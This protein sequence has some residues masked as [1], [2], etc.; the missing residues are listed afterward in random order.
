MS[1]EHGI[2]V[3]EPCVRCAQG[4]ENKHHVMVRGADGQVLD[5]SLAPPEKLYAERS[6]RDL[7]P[8][9][10]RHVAAMTAEGLHDKSAIAAELAHRDL[11][12]ALA[13]LRI[14]Q[15]QHRI[16]DLVE[17]SGRQ[18][19][20]PPDGALKVSWMCQVCTKRASVVVVARFYNAWCEPPSG[21]LFSIGGGGGYVCSKECAEKRDEIHQRFV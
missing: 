21:W 18:P 4:G 8:F 6:P 10:H 3:D 7:E 20:T 16:D 13:H 5:P 12:L 19:N 17:E 2:P 11:L 14:R 1:C 9:Y 15:L